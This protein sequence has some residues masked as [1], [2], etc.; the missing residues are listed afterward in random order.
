MYRLFFK[1]K[2]L[3]FIFSMF[4]FSGVVE[5][6]AVTVTLS[7]GPDPGYAGPCQQIAED[8]AKKTGNQVKMFYLPGEANDQLAVYQQLFSAKH[9]IPDVI[10]VDVIWPSILQ[11]YLLDLKQYIPDSHIEQHHPSL[12]KSLTIKNK[13]VAIP[14]YNET[15]VLYYRKDLLKKYN[16]PVPETWEELAKTAAFIMREE[17]KYSPEM[18][19]YIWDGRPYEGLTCNV[20]EWIGSYR[21][22]KIIEDDGI[23]SVNNSK[24]I[25]ALEMAASWVGTIS[26]EEILTKR[27]SHLFTVGNAVFKRGWSGGLGAKPWWSKGRSV[28]NGKVG[29]APLPKGG[30]NGVACGTIGTEN[31][32]VSMFSKYDKE[33]AALVRYLTSK[34]AQ[35]KL[36]GTASYNPSISSLHTHPEILEALPYLNSSVM[37]KVSPIARPSFVTGRRYNK[38]TK[39]IWKAAHSVLSGKKSAVDAVSKL[40]KDLKRIKRDGWPELKPV[41]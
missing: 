20:L 38:V 5:L 19:G 18:T 30:H 10:R 23:I 25:Q 33:A 41:Y 31:L 13:L 17:K 12:R 37:N 9:T 6:R 27:M 28:I 32:G 39:K 2:I 26:P 35:I 29:V 40:E 22:G 7:C 4:F 8:W 36:A 16:R 21:G 14:F 24:S 34:E 11:K 3:F 15:G 1:T